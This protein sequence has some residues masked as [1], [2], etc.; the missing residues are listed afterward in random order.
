MNMNMYWPQQKVFLL[1][2]L[3]LFPEKLTTVPVTI[4]DDWYYFNSKTNDELLQQLDTYRR[5]GYFEFNEV[6]LFVLGGPDID[7]EDYSEP[8][9][10]MIT[11]VNSQKVTDDLMEYLEDWRNDKLSTN[12]AYKPDDHSYQYRR[13]STA[14]RRV[15]RRHAI[16]HINIVDL[17]GDKTHRYNYDPPFWETVLSPHLITGQYRILQMNYD[18]KSGGQPFVDIEITSKELLRDIELRANNAPPISDEEPKEFTHNGLRV[19]RDGLVDYNGMDIQLN[20]QETTVLRALMER[21]EELRLKED[22]SIDLSAKGAESAN[23]AKLIS[24]LRKKLEKTIGY[25]CIESKSGLG[26]ILKIL[27]TE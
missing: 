14:L 11:H 5:A 1:G 9:A 12:T 18:F 2:I 21:P 7:S 6:P 27:P 23:L 15:Y 17:Y 13:L 24:S 20:G 4:N 10:Y 16:P 22:I 26:W 25:N 8:H 19:K 3:S